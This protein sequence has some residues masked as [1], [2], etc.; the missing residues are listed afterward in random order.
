[1]GFAR[2]L[3]AGALSGIALIATCAWA[4]TNAPSF[5]CTSAKGMDAIICADPG[6][7]ARDN[8][9]AALY[10]TARISPIGGKPSN[11]VKFQRDWLANRNRDCARDAKV[12]HCLTVEYDDRLQ[13]LAIATLFQVHDPAMAELHRQN[14]RIAAI[15]EAIYRH[16]TINDRAA[17]ANAVADI[18]KPAFATARQADDMLLKGI[19]TAHDA[20]ASDSAFSTLLVVL[21]THQYGDQNSALLM[22][23]AALARNPGLIEALEPK[24]GGAI[25][26]MTP[27]SDC[28]QV[29]PSMPQ[30]DRLVDKAVKMQP[31][32]EGTIRFTLGQ[33]YEQLLT[34]IRLHQMNAIKAGH[35][36][37]AA[38]FAKANDA[39][40]KG[41]VADMADWY[42]T[43]FGAAPPDAHSQATLA[44]NAAIAGAFN[45]C[46]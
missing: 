25:D 22:P 24:Y 30:F 16:V 26:G 14:P 13:E 42:A 35:D 9:M 2:L 27:S 5:S 8:T 20:A 1:M 41:A 46:D 4:Q 19:A 31:A 17:R 45:L 3:A 39:L 21:S 7:A 28:E 32:C 15:Y 43:G 44:V 37:G 29:L 18:I 10:H 36:A 11:E 12:A 6:L 33:S 34:N 40:V 23:C 38:K